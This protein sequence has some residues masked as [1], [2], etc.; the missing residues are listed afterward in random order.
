MYSGQGS[1]YY[2]MGKELYLKNDVFRRHMNLCSDLLSHELDRP[3]TEVIYD[4]SKKTENFDSILY[5]HPAIFSIGYSLTHVLMESGLR[6]DY[7]LGYSLGEFVASVVAGVVSLE[8]GLKIVSKQARMLHEKCALGG[9]MV[10][11]TS[12]DYFN[13]HQALFKNCMLAGINYSQCFV[14][15]G[16]K[17][18]LQE[19]NQFMTNDSKVSYILPV[20]YP[21]H[22]ALIEPIKND[23]LSLIHHVHY[24]PASIPVYSCASV[25]IMQT[26]RDHFWNVIRSP[27][28]FEQTIK[29]MASENDCLFIDLS[30]TG[31]MSNFIK[32]GFNNTITSLQ[33]MNQ[34]GKN[35]D[36]LNNLFTQVG[37]YRSLKEVL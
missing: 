21:F 9:M 11:F 25:G 5:T 33:L 29:S 12:P 24:E 18:R 16:S 32:H 26:S 34:F 31:T 7:L 30:P 3:L 4:E 28:Q 13:Q 27:I 35:I 14:V 2:N 36:T 20:N 17:E 8:D 15:S 6:P 10:V 37:K 23:F 22:S 1:Q 19:I